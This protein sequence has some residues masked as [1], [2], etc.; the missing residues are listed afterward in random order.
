MNFQIIPRS[1]SSW[2]A[3]QELAVETYGETPNEHSKVLLF[4]TFGANG[5]AILAGGC[6]LIEAEGKYLMADSVV[7]SPEL[8]EVSRKSALF[9]LLSSLRYMGDIM[10]LI[11]LVIASNSDSILLC[12]LGAAGY[13]DCGSALFF[14]ADSAQRD[15]EKRKQE[16][17]GIAV[18]D[19]LGVEA[20]PEKRGRGRP[21]KVVT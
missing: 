14:Y 15:Y 17:P 5:Q 8:D 18:D 10:G 2:R 6:I 1:A 13:K 19:D 4:E 20:R 11:V 16:Q 9:F 21:R 12:S 7:V 3:Y